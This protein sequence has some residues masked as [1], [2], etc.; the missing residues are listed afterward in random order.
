MRVVAI[1][2]LLVAASLG[3]NAQPKD[4]WAKADLQTVRLAPR[5]FTQLPKTI[6]ADL[7]KRG[8][9]IPQSYMWTKPHNIARGEFKRNGQKDWAVLCSMRR[10]SA[11][12][13]YWNASPNAVS[14]IAEKKDADYLTKFN[15]ERIGFSR[16]IAVANTKFIADHYE[17]YG[18]TKPPRLTHQGIEDGWAEKASELHYLHRSKWLKLQGAD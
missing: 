8:C 3:T 9:S 17:S 15:Q 6:I 14:R 7:E 10:S 5:K 18:G 1:V 11:I 4:D 2:I 16:I 12:L 13:I